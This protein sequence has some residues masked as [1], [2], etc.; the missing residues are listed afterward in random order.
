MRAAD[1]IAFYG[2]HSTSLLA[3]YEFVEEESHQGF[4]TK[5][6]WP[7]WRIP[8]TKDVWPVVYN[9]LEPCSSSA[10]NVQ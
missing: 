5:V 4:E 9:V 3:T 1:E 10:K 7:Q 2:G 8:D 6:H